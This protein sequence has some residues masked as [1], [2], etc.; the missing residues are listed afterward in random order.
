M[1][2]QTSFRRI[3]LS[4]ILLLSVP[5]LLMGEYI[6][7]RKARS[8][9]LDT[10]RQNLIESAIRKANNLQ[11]EIA[12]VKNSLTL[13]ASAVTPTDAAVSQQL[14]DIER[15][16]PLAVE[17]LRLQDLRQRTTIASTC[18]PN[19]DRAATVPADFWTRSSRRAIYTAAIPPSP[20]TDSEPP[21]T[22]FTPELSS[23]AAA[24]LQLVVG[25]AIDPEDTDAP[26]YALTALVRF[27]DTNRADRPKSLVGDRI[28]VG[29]DGTFLEHFDR[30]LLGR[31][32][33]TL[34]DTEIEERYSA[35]IIAARSGREDFLHLYLEPADPSW[36]QQGLHLLSLYDYPQEAIAGY[37]AIPSPVVGAENAQPWTILAVARIDRALAGL[38]DIW[39]VLF[40]LVLGLVA[41]NLFATLYIG[42]ELARP[43]ERLGDYAASVKGRSAL[44]PIPR[45]F[46]I[47]E[48]DQLAEALNAMVDRLKAWAGELESAWQEAKTANRLKTEFLTTISHELRTPL[49]AIIG[50]VRLVRDE[51]CDS[52][53]EEFEFLQRA[54]D[55]AVHL[56][57]IINDILDISRIEAGTLAVSIEPV[58]LHQIV[59][60]V[61]DLQKNEVEAKGLELEVLADD[62]DLSV[63][64]DSAKFKQVLLNVVGNAIKFTHE[65]KVT[66]AARI[67]A[68]S[69]NSK[70]IDR[71]VVTITDTG[72]GVDPADR[73]KVFEPFVMVNA[74][75]TRQYAGT[76][77]GLAISRNLM[78]LMGGEITLHSPGVDRGTT[79]EITLP[80]S[81]MSQQVAT[82]SNEQ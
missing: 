66:I 21:D 20:E 17:C 73:H 2:G 11:T 65:G 33:D 47:R 52:R 18:T 30:D 1:A 74:S 40:T 38:A 45:R 59:W 4:R 31:S 24:A 62:R 51:C 58:N 44:D 22:T 35:I 8:A 53:E 23:P 64:A 77:L 15:Q 55:A 34:T 75:T 63:Q 12:T 16:L 27:A 29:S 5:V 36:W 49:N 39:Q 48:L 82:M 68:A 79:V 43:V 81:R 72:I 7:Y 25:V 19:R 78:E 76:G 14:Q 10:A 56:L 9:L 13:A 60:E 80:R 46:K 32:L 26:R 6:T 54:D 37:A 70:E 42:R 57:D 61:V 71:V 69:N 67:D 41:A 3:L 28:I 50:C